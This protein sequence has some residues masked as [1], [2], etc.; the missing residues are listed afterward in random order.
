MSIQIVAATSLLIVITCAVLL[1]GGG[2]IRGGVVGVGICYSLLM[3]YLLTLGVEDSR[4]LFYE[5]DP[6]LSREVSEKSYATNCDFNLK[7]LEKEGALDI[8]VFAHSIGYVAKMLILRDPFM[9]WAVSLLFEHAENTFQHILPNFLECWWDHLILDI[10][11]CNALGIIGGQILI[12]IFSLEKYNW[13]GGVSKSAINMY[14]ALFI[15]TFVLLGDLSCFFLKSLLNH[16]PESI[17]TISRMLFWGIMSIFSM[18]DYYRY[19]KSSKPVSFPVTSLVALVGFLLEL[20]VVFLFTV[21]SESFTTP[22][23]PEILYSWIVAVNLF[24]VSAIAN[25]ILEMRLLGVCG[26]IV[27][28][29]VLVASFIVTIPGIKPDVIPHFEEFISLV[30]NQYR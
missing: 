24:V 13:F 21:Q 9:A 4:E 26:V 16:P 14:H 5:L 29:A 11:V 22:C 15:L 30:E 18:G 10:L 2:F 17:F 3:I 23:P 8:F 25:Y 28:T 19:I 7:T 12:K 27:G 6:S 20:S 1:R